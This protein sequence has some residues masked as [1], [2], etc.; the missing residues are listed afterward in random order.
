MARS[1]E[2]GECLQE[3][4]LVTATL[5]IS[6]LRE[7]LPNVGHFFSEAGFD[8][9]VVM[10]GWGAKLPNEELWQLLEIPTVQ[11]QE[12]AAQGEKQGIFE[13]GKSDLIIQT[14]GKEAS[15]TLCHESD[16]HFVSGD[17]LLL[18]TFAEWWRG[19]GVGLSKS[20][21]TITGP[22]SWTRIE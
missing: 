6:Q 11:I 5:T 15:L 17:P 12:F 2:N 19:K 3:Q 18:E 21:R 10:Y 16:V 20:S 4:E 13:L 1:H 14:T 9:V 22:R 8:T 7:C